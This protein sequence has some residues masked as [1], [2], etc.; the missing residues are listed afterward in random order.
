M[1]YDYKLQ[2]GVLTDDPGFLKRYTFVDQAT[3][4]RTPYIF[5]SE[6]DDYE[7]EY[8][9]DLALTLEEDL[10]VPVLLTQDLM[11]SPEITLYPEQEEVAQA[12]IKKP[13][14][15]LLSAPGSGKTVIALSLI[16][17]LNFKTLILVNT[18]YLLRQWEEAFKDFYSYNVGV[19]GDKSFEIKDITVATFQTMLTKGKNLHE[20]WSL[21][22]VD[23]CHHISAKTFYTVLR[24]LYA[25]YKI[26]LTVTLKRKDGLEP[27]VG[28][29]LGRRVIENEVDNT[30]KEEIVLVKTGIKLKGDTFVECLTNLVE[31]DKLHKLVVAQVNKAPDR[32]QL[33]LCSRVETVSKLQEL[34]PDAICVIGETK[35]EDRANLNERVLTNRVIISTLLNEGV[36]LPNVDT[37]HLIHPSNNIPVLTQRVARVT[38]TIEGK[39]IPL[40]F[41]YLFSS[42]NNGFSV[43]QQQ[44]IRLNWYKSRNRKIYTIKE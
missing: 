17:S 26:G 42:N 44:K 27:I 3:G 2:G 33:I 38:R 31:S 18:T 22:I 16:K 14:G 24:S 21:I 15:I 1:K 32:H 39:K 25:P 43:E 40:V 9:Y 23:E 13:Y 37:L 10:K 28:Y 7:Y 41:D 8:P 29:F 19:I 11:G 30:M 36:N 34:L 35:S 6:D 4:I 5:P 12:F 20:E